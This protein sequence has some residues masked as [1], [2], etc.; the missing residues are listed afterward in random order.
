MAL[1]AGNGECSVR[2]SLRVSHRR[3]QEHT[4]HQRGQ[5][6]FWVETMRPPRA[7]VRTGGHL[8]LVDH[9]PILLVVAL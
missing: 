8:S 7:A 9:C 5:D 4:H 6:T 3:T 1:F 2:R